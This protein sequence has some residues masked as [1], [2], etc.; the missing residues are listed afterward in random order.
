MSSRRGIPVSGKVCFGALGADWRLMCEI[1]ASSK[2][3]Q[4]SILNAWLFFRYPLSTLL[5]SVRCT[6]YPVEHGVFRTPYSSIHAHNTLHTMYY[7]IVV[8]M[9][10]GAMRSL[11]TDYFIPREYSPK[12]ANPCFVLRTGRSI[13]CRDHSCSAYGRMD[14]PAGNDSIKLR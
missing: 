10:E 2:F 9:V 3:E 8:E 7:S 6:L 12:R 1:R 11:P 13:V 4:Y 14:G 5:C